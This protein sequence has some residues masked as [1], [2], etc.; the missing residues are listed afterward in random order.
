[1]KR[2]TKRKMKCRGE[3]SRAL[4][5][6][7]GRCRDGTSGIAK[8]GAHGRDDQVTSFREAKS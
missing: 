4:A 1:M 2:K 5:L 6:I 3:K 8:E 7:V